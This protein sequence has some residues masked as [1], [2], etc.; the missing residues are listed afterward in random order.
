MGK[1]GC[2]G[3]FGCLLIVIAV[4]GLCGLVVIPVLP[5]FAENE[6][7]D[8]LLTPLVCQSG[9]TILRDQYSG[10]SR[11]GG[12]SYSM[13]VYCIDKEG[14]RRDETERWVLLSMAIFTAP[15]LLGL[16]MIIGGASRGAAKMATSVMSNTSTP[17]AGMSTTSYVMPTQQPQG[18]SLSER[19]KQLDDAR[20][21]GLITADEYDQMRKK[22][23]DES[24]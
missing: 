24:K 12:T 21:Q 2:F 7:I 5:P 11:D 15:F 6:T 8:G 17:F 23:L 16:F 20:N 9:E 10:P 22:I 13:D 3:C 19:L 4:V 1:F 18:G 14:E